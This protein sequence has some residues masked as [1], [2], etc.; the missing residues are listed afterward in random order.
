MAKRYSG[1]AAALVCVIGLAAVVGVMSQSLRMGKSFTDE[2]I[3]EESAA[4]D[5]AAPE[6]AWDDAAV[7]ESAA[8]S[9]DDAAGGN[10][11]EVELAD[12][13][14]MKLNGRIDRLDS[15]DDGNHISIKIIDYKSGNTKF[16][17]VRIYQGL[18]VWPAG[19]LRADSFAVG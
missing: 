11:L 13:V 14:R 8:E 15:Y 10:A 17:L 12:D 16:D 18:Q 1:L 6:E 3:A 2:G 19:G 4:A 5:T 9:A 7:E